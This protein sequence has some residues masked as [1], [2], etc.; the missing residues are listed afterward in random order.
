MQPS[1]HPPLA[2]PYVPA[3]HFTRRYSNEDAIIRGTLF[4]ELDLPFNHYEIRKPLPDTPMTAL[5][6]IDFVCHELR[7][8]LDTHPDDMHAE[9]LHK[10]YMEKSE[11]AKK[12]VFG[13]GYDWVFDPW[14]WEV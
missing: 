8:Y 2:Y 1:H 11:A 13:D 9:S 10:E 14:P 7:L 5:M 6:Q 3:Q 12:Q 4:P